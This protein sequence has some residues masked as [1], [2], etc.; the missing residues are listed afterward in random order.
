MKKAVT[1]GFL[2]MI[3]CVLFIPPQ[4]LFSK[5]IEPLFGSAEPVSCIMES[6]SFSFFNLLDHDPKTFASDY[7]NTEYPINQ[8][9]TIENCIEP[10][11]NLIVYCDRD[12]GIF[13]VEVM[14]ANFGSATSV[15]VQDNRGNS[16]ELNQE[17]S[18]TF[19]DYDYDDTITITAFDTQDESCFHSEIVDSDS[20]MELPCQLAEPFCSSEGLFFANSYDEDE[21]GRNSA[22]EGIDYGCLETT[23][24]PAWFYLKIDQPGDLTLHI[25]QNTEFSSEGEPVGIGLD[26]DFVAWGPFQSI[27][28]ACD[29]ILPENQVQDNEM[30]DGCSYAIDE[31]E[32]LGIVGAKKGDIYVLLITNYRGAK[33][34]IQVTQTAGQASTDCTIVIDE[35][36][37]ACYDEDVWLEAETLSSTDMYIW[38]YLNPVTQEYEILPGEEERIL[39]VEE[40]GNY[41]VDVYQATETH[42]TEIFEVNI[43]ATPVFEELEGEATLCDG[44]EI[45]LNGR[46]SNEE[47]YAAVTYKWQDAN[48]NEL[49]NTPLLEVNEIGIYTLWV[50]MQSFDKSG[51]PIE[52]SCQ[53]EKEIQV[54]LPKTELT[55]LSDQE[56]FQSIFYC[57]EDSIPQYDFTLEAVLESAQ[58]PSISYVWYKN[59]AEIA[60]HHSNTLTVSY[61]SEGDFQDVYSV[62]VAD[63]NC[64]F[65]AEREVHISILP[66][67]QPCR[68]TEG[69]SPGNR[70]GINDSLDLAFLQERT[71]IE[72]LMIYNRYGAEV[73]KKRDYTNE[74]FGQDQNGKALV[75]GTY[76]Y[77]IQLKK[78]DP[79]FGKIKKG[80]I[81][82][83]Q[84]TN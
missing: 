32:D 38:Y 18:V 23:P 35:T 20:C 25:V 42:T 26:V 10:D 37:N 62:W 55:I 58:N 56:V 52:G 40:S 29:N 22:P 68:I 57:R 49:S 1:Y 30:G 75:S 11:F 64:F 65:E 17:G 54:D 73:Y 4:F 84:N 6:D 81:Y 80:W 13:D 5:S 53:I 69:I 24:N 7:F 15:T 47:D 66:Y 39:L 36:V 67:E 46:L 48:G 60:N 82:V 16:I 33:G 83:N 74:W 59:G 78:E 79:V 51:N 8:S 50:D 2:A 44:Q 12:L 21:D 34:F 70:D 63:G 77:V 9:K 45:V 76:Y 14:V 61:T 27:E 41:R 71:G 19:Y 31:E 3:W 43:S 72:S 28:E